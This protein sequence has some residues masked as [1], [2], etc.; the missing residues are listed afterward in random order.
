M[1]VKFRELF[2]ERSVKGSETI[3]KEYDEPKVTIFDYLNQIWTK[4]EKHSYDKKIAPAWQLTAWI[5]Q[6][7]EL[8]DHAQEINKN[9][10]NMS[11]EMIYKYYFYSIPKSRKRFIKWTRKDQISLK[12]EKEI[13]IIMADFEISHREATM[14]LTHKKR[15]IK[16]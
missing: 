15:I 11:D 13:G 8:I 3:K 16:K 6:V 10:F 1:S 7:P 5:A 4:K 12:Q 2:Y 14:L 9:M